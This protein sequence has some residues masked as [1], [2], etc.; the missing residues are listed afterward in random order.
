MRTP[1]LVIAI[2]GGSGSGKT[3]LAHQLAEAFLPRTSRI[4]AQDS[5]F[6]SLPREWKNRPAE[7]NFDHPDA[8]D[9]DCLVEHLIQLKHGR[10]AAVPR[11]CFITHRRVDS[12]VVLP[13][14]ILIYEG[15]MILH[16]LRLCSQSHLKVYLDVPPDIRVLRRLERDVKERGRTMESVV[17]QYRATV[18]PMHLEYV[19]SSQFRAA[20]ILPDGPITEWVTQ[21]IRSLPERGQP[22]G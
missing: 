11:Y 3:F 16:D 18:R 9:W 5:Y 4:I 6:K 19:E 14:E 21:V 7:Y 10:E 8:L 1:P 2:A 17:H 13:A 15:T 20:L 22:G 12:E